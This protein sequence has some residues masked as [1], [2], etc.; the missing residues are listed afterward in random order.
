[1]TA[2]HQVSDGTQME[3]LERVRSLEQALH[4][5]DEMLA[6]A[7]HE[8]RNPMHSLLL[9]VTAA[10]KVAQLK[11][12]SGMQERLERMKSV[13]ERYINRATVLLDACRYRTHGFQLSLADCDLTE[14]LKQLVEAFAAEAAFNQCEL[15]LD[16][17]DRVVG[18]W[19]RLALE[20][21]AAN[22][23]SNAI[24]YGAGGAVTIRVD[25]SS[26]ESVTMF[27]V[28]HGIGIAPDDQTRIFEQFERVAGAEARGSGF[29]VGL[30]LVRN[31]V[32]A[33]SGTVQLRSELGRGS[34]FIVMLPRTPAA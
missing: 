16:V 32:E 21:I 5:R 7:A 15:A 27:V 9:Q 29:G 25:A 31:L 4:A 14:V 19:D 26:P 33:H 12:D 23:I 18:C 13:V 34:T 20:Q 10:L 17:P 24:K 2:A 28:D 11:G 8:L 30:W 22:L 3:L 6:V 1:M